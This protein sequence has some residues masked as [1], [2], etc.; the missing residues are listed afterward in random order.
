MNLNKLRGNIG[1]LFKLQPPA[2]HLDP[3][4]RELPYVD[5]EW[6]LQ[7]VSADAATIT[8]RDLKILGL[9]TTV[10]ADV[11]HHFDTD[12]SRGTRHGFLMLGQ[13]MF[14]KANSITYRLCSRPGQRVDPLPLPQIERVPVDFNFIRTSG[15]EQ[16]LQAEGFEANGVVAQRLAERE[17]QGWERV[18]VNDRHGNPTEYFIADSRPGMELIFIK[19]RK[20]VAEHH[21]GVVRKN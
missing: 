3:S 18:I 8:V 2:I 21:V 12:R 17:L 11:V 14:I 6:L 19:K 15:I 9:S 20:P 7:D 4:G 10:G 16:R 1:W 5:E 13:Q